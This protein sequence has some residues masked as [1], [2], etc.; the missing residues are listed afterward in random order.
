MND[1]YF[2]SKSSFPAK[3]RK[4]A[5][6]VNR[7]SVEAAP[8]PIWCGVETCL[9]VWHPPKDEHAGYYT[10]GY[11]DIAVHLPDRTIYRCQKCYFDALE[12][13]GKTQM[14]VAEKQSAIVE[15]NT[16]RRDAKNAIDNG[17]VK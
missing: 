3:S 10:R 12:S 8:K 11:A 16:L 14:Q 15:E 13:A 6:E 9:S 17:M 5:G 4:Y 7:A 1:D 2:P